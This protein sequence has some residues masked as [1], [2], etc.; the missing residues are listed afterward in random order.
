MALRRPIA[1]VSIC[2]F[3]VAVLAVSPFGFALAAK[4]ATPPPPPTCAKAEALGLVGEKAAARKVYAAVLE[5]DPSSPCAREGLEELNGSSLHPAAADCVRGDAYLDLDRNDDAIKAFKAALEKNPQAPCA[6]KGLDQAGPGKLERR[7]DGIVASLPT[8]LEGLGLAALALFL[9]LLLGYIPILRVLIRK[10]PLLRRLIG[11]RLS[12]EVFEDEAVEG[13]PGA[14]IAARI[15]ERLHRMREEAAGEEEESYSLD[16]STPREDFADLVSENGSLKTSLE[17]ASDV[18]DQ[19]KIV[20]A[21]LN[22]AYALL[23]IQRIS[24]SATMEPP[25]KSGPAATF[26]LEKNARLEAAT[27]MRGPAPATGDP[28]AADYSRLADPAAVWVQYEV[29]RVLSSKVADDDAAEAYALVRKGLDYQLAGEWR[30][31]R[32]SYLEAIAL[33]RSGWGAY[34]NLAVADA[35]LGND[36]D[37][38]IAMLRAGFQEAQEAN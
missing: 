33:D 4:D 14:P 34:V 25:D 11:P 17:N 9:L 10:L 8:V 15:K 35:W 6:T 16:F 5:A 23:P 13:K 29:A 28:T 38:S 3:T 32:A 22:F 12:I 2:L 37:S 26:L 20:A 19:T 18:S 7:I 1:L 31:A 27:T 30:K 21:V 24:I 36:F